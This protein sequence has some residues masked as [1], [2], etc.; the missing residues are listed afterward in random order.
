MLEPELFEAVLAQVEA[1]INYAQGTGRDW[2]IPPKKGDL[3]ELGS[4]VC[5]L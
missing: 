5:R 4:A 2:A 1:V 3:L